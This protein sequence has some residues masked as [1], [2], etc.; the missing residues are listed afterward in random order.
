ML[1]SL[2]E[3]SNL[4]IQLKQKVLKKIYLLLW[5]IQNHPGDQFLSSLKTKLK[6]LSYQMKMSL[7][8]NNLNSMKVT[9]R[10][11]DVLYH[12][13]NSFR[14]CKFLKHS[15]VFIWESTKPFLWSK[16]TFFNTP[17]T[18]TR[19]LLQ[20]SLLVYFLLLLGF[21]LLHFLSS[22]KSCIQ[23][24]KPWKWTF[25]SKF[26]LCWCEYGSQKVL[27]VCSI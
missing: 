10:L 12:K 19:V 17:L 14:Y 26:R 27:T 13:S 4:F 23:P 11:E 8:M 24:L 18:G 25:A 16:S 21:S 22:A 9:W 20:L 6:L 15:V 7:P 3:H 1:S 2:I 5:L